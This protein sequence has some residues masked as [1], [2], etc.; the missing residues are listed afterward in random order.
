MKITFLG[1]ARQVTGS[2][3]LIE[4]GEIKFLVD[5]GMF[6]GGKQAEA[7]NSQPFPYRPSE[8]AFVLL[9][10]AHIDH[11]GLLPRLVAEG[12]DGPIYTTTATADLVE[13]MLPDS[14]HI[15]EKEAEKINWLQSQKSRKQRKA[16]P[17]APLYTTEQ[18]EAC[19]GQLIKLPYD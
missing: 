7:L 1:A 12:F 15:Q 17:A 5:C 2:S 3:Y 19:L 11:S 14:A 16:P 10:H 18:A 9:T 6:Q 4:T 8:L 13:V